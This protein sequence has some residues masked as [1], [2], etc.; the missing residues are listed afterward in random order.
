MAMLGS[1]IPFP[2]TRADRQRTSDP[3]ASIEERYASKAAYLERVREVT[4]RLIASRYVLAD[5]LEAIVDR[6]SR[7]WDWVH[8]PG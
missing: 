2:P 4:R 8:N 7:V 1:T 5:D 3:R 6:A